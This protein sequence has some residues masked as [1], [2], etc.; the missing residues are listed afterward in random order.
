MNAADLAIIQS[1][2][3]DPSA[4]A[5][6]CGRDICIGELGD[7]DAFEACVQTC[8]LDD[9]FPNFAF[10]G[11]D[12]CSRCFSAQVRCIG[13]FCLT[14]C[15]GAESACDMCRWENGC[16]DSFYE[17]SGLPRSP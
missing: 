3:K 6:S 7:K 14:Q 4:K 15:Q 8:M 10:A 2:D 13:E 9:T 11:S 5:A 12:G 17:C 16:T 1:G